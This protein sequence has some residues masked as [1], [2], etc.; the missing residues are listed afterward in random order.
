VL[1][2]DLDTVMV[3]SLKALDLSRPIREADTKT[4]VSDVRFWGNSGH[5]ANVSQCPLM[6]QSS[7]LQNWRSPPQCLSERHGRDGAVD[8]VRWPESNGPGRYAW[9]GD[10]G[11]LAGLAQDLLACGVRH[12][13][14]TFDK[15]YT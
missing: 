2:S 7:E 8:F 15:E 9:R 12:T 6:T 1:A 4:P 14:G 5:W 13:H 10:I 3:D 11:A